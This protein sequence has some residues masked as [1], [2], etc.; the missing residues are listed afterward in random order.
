MHATNARDSRRA[1]RQAM[2]I[3]PPRELRSVRL[4]IGYKH[5][6]NR[7]Q[8]TRTDHQDISTAISLTYF[9]CFVAIVF[10]GTLPDL[11][12]GGRL[13]ACVRPASCVR[14]C[15]LPSAHVRSVRR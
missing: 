12:G 1:R 7:L 2:R 4:Y 11:S 14:P 9:S 8:S 3:E 6:S 15:V 13:P 5:Y 10:M